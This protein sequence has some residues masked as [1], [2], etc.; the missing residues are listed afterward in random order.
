M[1]ASLFSF[2]PFRLVPLSIPASFSH[3]PL[4]YQLPCLPPPP[5]FTHFPSLP[6]PT[7]HC[8]TLLPRQA[9]FPHS[10]PPPPPSF[11]PLS[12]Q[13]TVCPPTSSA[14]FVH[15]VLHSKHCPSKH[16]SASFSAESSASPDLMLLTSFPASVGPDNTS[17]SGRSC[18]TSFFRA[19]SASCAPVR[20]TARVRLELAFA[21]LPELIPSFRPA[22]SLSFPLSLTSP[23]SF[24]QGRPDLRPHARCLELHSLFF[25]STPLL[26]LATSPITLKAT[27]AT[28]C[29]PSSIHLVSSLSQSLST[30][31]PSSCSLFPSSTICFSRHPAT[32][33]SPTTHMRRRF[34][35]ILRLP[36]YV[37]RPRS[38]RADPRLPVA[39][40]VP[41]SPTQ[42]LC[43]LLKSRSL[44][45]HASLAAAA[46]RLLAEALANVGPLFLP[47]VPQQAVLL[48]Q[49][50]HLQLSFPRGR[51]F[52]FLHEGSPSLAEVSC[53]PFCHVIS[54]PMPPALNTGR[55]ACRQADSLFPQAAL[56]GNRN[57]CETPTQLPEATLL[58]LR[59][60]C[61]PTSVL[62][63]S[64]SPS[65]P[66]RI[67]L[68][69]FAFTRQR[70]YPRSPSPLAPSL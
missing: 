67:P 42:L 44:S 53:S 66:S 51:P 43:V 1:E 15:A 58:S 14:S 62:S 8:F 9:L 29:S 56:Q 59:Q 65:T 11:A 12:A 27:A 37:C 31:P 34:K 24:S 50:V 39:P 61:S 17:C 2:L 40:A 32:V 13:L 28:L 60:K 19:R 16:S 55:L 7:K 52:P 68:A 49:Q 70:Q 25:V 3:S 46:E 18:S 30:L 41:R 20:L 54:P 38:N 22:L 57:L 6:H 4:L 69:V 47:P 33:S 26:T 21:N 45:Q 63:R 23:L 36:L 5:L 10:F 48:L 35:F 64:R